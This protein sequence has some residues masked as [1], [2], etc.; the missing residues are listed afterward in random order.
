MG[1]K[2]LTFCK[3]TCLGGSERGEC[4]CRGEY[5]C[6]LKKNPGYQ[7]ARNEAIVRMQ[8]HMNNI[9]IQG[10]DASR[11]DCRLSQDDGCFNFCHH[12]DI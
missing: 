10:M 1:S 8:R 7:H 6:E 4:P 11:T 12:P 9:T 3:M 5:E 2:F